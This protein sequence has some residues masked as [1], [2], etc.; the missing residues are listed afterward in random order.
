M[1]SYHAIITVN[2]PVD[3]YAP[4]DQLVMSVHMPQVIVAG[5]FVVLSLYL[6]ECRLSKQAP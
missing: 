6:L 2:D 3:N 4:P 5:N 1:K